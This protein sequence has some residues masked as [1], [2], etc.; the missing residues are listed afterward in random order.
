MS[1]WD[2]PLYLLVGNPAP[3]ILT[4]KTGDSHQKT[5]S[6]LA[7]EWKSQDERV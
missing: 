7:A 5:H 3:P 1:Q 2:L 4:L 6:E